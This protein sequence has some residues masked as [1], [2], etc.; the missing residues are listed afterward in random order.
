[1]KNRIEQSRLSICR[2]LFV[3]PVEPPNPCHSLCK[4]LVKVLK[5][6]VS[7]CFRLRPLPPLDSEKF[8]ESEQLQNPGG[9]FSY[10][11][12]SFL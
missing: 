12:F 11:F 2:T 3:G 10:D 9:C 7:K 8:E 4:L 6:K 5:N 1:M